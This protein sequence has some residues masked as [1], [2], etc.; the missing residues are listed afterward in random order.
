MMN[1]KKTTLSLLVATAVMLSGCSKPGIEGEVD[2]PNVA[3]MQINADENTTSNYFPAIA[4]AADLTAMSFRINGEIMELNA[5]DGQ[6][7]KKGDLLAKLDE[8]DYLIE[9][10][11]AQASY[12]V[13]DSQ[14][15]RSK[16]LVEKELLAQS[17][18]DE[19]RAK[20]AIAKADLDL[21]KLRLS[22]TELVAPFDGIISR[23][24]VDNFQ[25][26][27][28]G[29]FLFNLH[30]VDQVEVLVQIP[31]QLVIS[32][33]NPKS[34]VNAQVRTSTGNEYEASLKEY[35]S[36]PDPTTGTYTVTLTMP[37]PE[38]EIILDGMA[39]DVTNNASASDFSMDGIVLLPV[40]AV[41]NPDGQSLTVGGSHVWVLNEDNTVTKQQVT[42]GD[43]HLSEIQITDGVNASDTVV[44][45]GNAQLRD[46]MTVNPV[47]A[48]TTLHIEDEVVSDE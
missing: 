45:A 5:K 6:T 41:V 13:I 23:L 7:V 35:T 1:T 9:V 22:F 34:Q 2:T 42:L 48:T 30:K 19:I 14:F 3:V 26:V 17:Q 15:T 21:A 25:T 29:E 10:E 4:L 40:E 24:D 11:N 37:M 32:N 43:L 20:R 8:R 28:P 44:I 33:M 31:D 38:D 46:G 36:E 39:L 12:E 18:F 16:P 27:A 47:E